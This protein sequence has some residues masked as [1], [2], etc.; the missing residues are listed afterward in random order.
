MKRVRGQHAGL[1]RAMVL[2]GALDL[3]DRQGAASLTMRG[4]AAEL[5]VEAMALYHHVSNKDQLLDGLVELV[6]G[7]A[8]PPESTGREWREFMRSYGLRLSARLRA[9]PEVLPLVAT[10]PALTPTVLRMLDRG[11]RVLQEGGFPPGWAL[12]AIH[13]VTGFVVGS[14]GA[15]PETTGDGGDPERVERLSAVELADFPAL[16]AAVTC[17]HAPGSGQDLFLVT[18]DALIEGLASAASR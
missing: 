1:T 6:V 16:Q 4:L 17:G 12:Q 18:L 5:G 11:V 14:L 8:V 2:G 7:D 13:V 3:V 15:F 10:R 9:H